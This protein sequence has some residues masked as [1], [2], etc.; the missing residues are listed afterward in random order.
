MLQ[1]GGVLRRGAAAL[2]AVG[3]AHQ[4]VVHAYMCVYTHCTTGMVCAH[5]ADGVTLVFTTG[6]CIVVWQ[7]ACKFWQPTAHALWHAPCQ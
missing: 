4:W 3:G 1:G 5:A 6:T 2:P 7:D